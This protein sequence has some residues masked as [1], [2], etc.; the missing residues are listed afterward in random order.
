MITDGI[1]QADFVLANF[2]KAGELLLSNILPMMDIKSF[3]SLEM[4]VGL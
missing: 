2:E 4:R 3:L 1:A